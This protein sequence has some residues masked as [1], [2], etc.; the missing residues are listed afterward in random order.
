MSLKSE[1]IASWE[2]DPNQWFTEEE[3]KILSEAGCIRWKVEEIL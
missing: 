2:H 1:I 3:M